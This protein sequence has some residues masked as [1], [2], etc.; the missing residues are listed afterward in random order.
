MKITNFKQIHN[1]FQI[2]EIDKQ[3]HIKHK[4]S[5]REPS[6]IRKGTNVHYNILQDAPELQ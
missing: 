3:V 6:E 5:L 1:Y 2:L 4:V